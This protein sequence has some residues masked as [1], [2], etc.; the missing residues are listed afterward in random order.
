[1]HEP[2]LALPERLDAH[3][4]FTGK[5]V[6][7][8][9]VD[10]AFVPHPDLSRPS[11]RIR[12][13]VD[14]ARDRPRPEH[15]LSTGA[16]VWHGTMTACAAVGNGYLSMGRYRGLAHEASA[17]LLAVRESADDTILGSR[18]AAALRFVLR[19]PELEVRVVN[20]SLGVDWSDPHVAEVEAAVGELVRAGVV[21]VAAAG[22]DEG[23]PPT[24]PGSAALALTV[25]GLDDR[26]TLRDADDVRWPSSAGARSGR[27]PKPD[28]LAPAV[29]LP[30][31]MVPGTLTEREAPVLFDLLRLLEEAE[32]DVL[33]RSGRPLDPARRDHA[34]LAKML[35]AVHERIAEQKYIAP[36]YQHVDGTSFAAPLVTSVVAQMLEACPSLGPSEVREGLTM[37]ARALPEVPRLLQG[38]GVV[39]P[40]AAVEWAVARAAERARAPRRPTSAAPR[41]A[42]SE[43][44]PARADAAPTSKRARA[45]EPRKPRG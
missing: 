30:A 16:H 26:N 7:V 45:T 3:P 4:G 29:R 11:S 41:E 33:F 12:A 19:H 43:R 39:T 17:V 1:M 27:S 18:V 9:F 8:G 42:T 20:V 34:S 37:T 6:T 25:G 44:A 2:I 21:V 10:S 36:S 31:P 32:S 13:F 23:A 15:F 35:R 24:P 38:A 40:R 14:L 5:G 28:L 22:N